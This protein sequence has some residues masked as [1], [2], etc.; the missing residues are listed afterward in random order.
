MVKVLLTADETL[1]STYRDIPLLDFLG[2]SPVERLPKIIYQLLEAQL[3]H[4]GG[5]LKVA[6]YSLRKVEAS[7]LK[8]GFK[9]EDVLVV[10]PR[11]VEK[12]LSEDLEIVG[13]STMDP[14]GLGPLSMM[15]SSGGRHTTLSKAKFLEL[16]GRL[17]KRP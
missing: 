14:L 13:I 7:L 12:Y 16:A 2:C 8:Y 1:T 9:R 6:P 3:P 4:E 11:F 17:K 5:V 15:F 10:H